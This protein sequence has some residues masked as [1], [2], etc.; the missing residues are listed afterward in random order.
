MRTVAALLAVL[1]LGCASASS[2]AASL[3]EPRRPA[4]SRLWSLDGRT[5]VV[6]GGS[7]VRSAHERG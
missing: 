4:S 6:T 1:G 7:K 3:I 5:A 2:A